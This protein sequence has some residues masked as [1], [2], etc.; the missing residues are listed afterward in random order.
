MCV[1]MCYGACV[2]VRGKLAGI[3]SCFPPHY[4]GSGNQTQDVSISSN[5]PHFLSHLVDPIKL[6]I[7]ITDDD[8]GDSDENA[9]EL[10]SFQELERW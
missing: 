7:Y 8:N 1:Y 9:I 3:D 4:I 10:S 5:C 6:L 2:E